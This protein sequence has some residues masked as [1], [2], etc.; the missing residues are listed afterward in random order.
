MDQRI[1]H[2]I[3]FLN[4]RPDIKKFVADSLDAL[5]QAILDELL[6]QNNPIKPTKSRLDSLSLNSK[7]D[8]NNQNN[9]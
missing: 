9:E 2:E 1:V 8:N 4:E 3:N 6:Y 7:Q 5:E